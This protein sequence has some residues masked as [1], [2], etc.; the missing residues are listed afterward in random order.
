MKSIAD[1]YFS[2]GFDNQDWGVKWS[3]SEVFVFSLP[4]ILFS[5]AF[6]NLRFFLHTLSAELPSKI[7]YLF[8]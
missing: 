7:G 3:S 8:Y 1:I 5:E 6:R 2:T 4:V